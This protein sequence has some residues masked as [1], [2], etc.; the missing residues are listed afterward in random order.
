MNS[1]YKRTHPCTIFIHLKI[2]VVLLL[3]PIIRQ[4]LYTPQDIFEIIGSMSLTTFYAVFVVG[5]AVYSYRKYLYRLSPHGI[6][7]KKGLFFNRYFTLPFT[8]IQTINIY[9]DVFMSLLGAEKVSFDSPGGTSRRY[10]ISAFFPKKYVARLIDELNKGKKK[11]VYTSNNFLTLLTCAFWSN[12]AAGLLF[13]SPFVLKLGDTVKYEIRNILYNSMNVFW[14]TIAIG[15]SP[16]AVT[17]ANV[18]FGGWAIAV[19]VEFFR[20]GKFSASRIGEYIVVSRGVFNRSTTYTR[21]DRVAAVT[22]NQSLFMRI[23]GLYSSGLFT[24]GAG[25]LKG[26]KGLIIAAEKHKKLHYCLGRLVKISLKERRSVCPKKNTLYSYICLPLWITAAIMAAL[27]TADY[28][29]VTDELFKVLMIFSVIPLVWWIMFRIFAHKHSHIAINK[30]YLIASG[31]DKWTLKKYII[32]FKQ[33]QYISITQSIFQRLKGT[34]NVHIYLYYEKRAYQTVKHLP[35]KQVNEIY[36][37]I[38]KYS[39]ERT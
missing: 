28:F 39:T 29:S 21:A 30:K 38:K 35:I 7:I 24:V 17:V 4:L 15:V 8:K 34:C 33:L 1:I 2:S 26:D 31:Y 20:Y 6:E 16:V 14:E 11:F 23:L 36:K 37:L 12:P 32:P 18:L 22:I 9:K 19:A 25:K 3:L 10:D 27:I 5:Y 13:I